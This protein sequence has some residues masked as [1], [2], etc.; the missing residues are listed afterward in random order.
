MESR[1]PQESPRRPTGGRKPNGSGGAPTPP[2]LWLLL[3]AGFGLI[4]WQFAPKNEVA[5]SYSP[6]FLDQVDEDNIKSLSLQGLEVR[7]E[8]RRKVT[9]HPPT[10]TAPQQVSRFITYF[11]SEPAIDTV[12]NKLREKEKEKEKLKQQVDEPVRIDPSPPQAANTFVWITLLLPTFVIVGLIYFMMRRAGDQVDGGILGSFVKSPAK[13]HDKSK[14]RTTFDEVAGLEN[15][16]S[17]LQ[18]IVEFLKN[19]EKFQRLRGGDPQSGLLLRPPGSGKTLL[20]R[21]VAGEAGVPFYSISGSEFIQMFV[22]VGASRVRDMF[23]TAKEN[24]PCILFIDEID[25]VGRVRGAG[26]GGG[27]DEREQTLNQ[28]LT[29]MDGFSPNESVIVLAATNRP[30]VL[31]PALLRPGRFDRHVTV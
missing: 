20:A 17:E 19:P 24:S 4:F 26:L 22:G 27:H 3:I 15:A 11:P 16:K 10:A 14:Q 6:W 30:D 12:V 1:P 23:K 25:A 2:W 18:E 7:G 21:A 31:D 8:L 9:Y 13:R 29:E 5:V 28:I